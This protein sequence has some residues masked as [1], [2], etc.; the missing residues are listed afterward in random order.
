MKRYF[1]IH[2]NFGGKSNGYSIPLAIEEKTDTITDWSSED[3][4]ANEAVRQGRLDA[5]DR[6]YVDTVDEIEEDEYNDMKGI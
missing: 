2:V 3:E 1:D 5:D 6:E 4:I